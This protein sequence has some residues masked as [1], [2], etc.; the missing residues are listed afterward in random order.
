ML[1]LLFQ[2]G[3]DRYAL[4][5]GA[6]AEVL[7]LVAITAIPQAPAG[8]AGLFNYRGAPVPAIDLS[9]LT[10]GR[11]ARRRLNTRIIMVHY[12]DARGDTASAGSHRREGHR[13]RAARSRGL[14][15]IRCHRRPRPVPGIGGH[16]RA[17]AAADGVDV[18]RL[19][20]LSV[21]M[22]C[23]P[24]RREPLMALTDFEDLLKA[25]IGLDVELDRRLLLLSAPCRSGSRHAACRTGRS[26]GS[27]CAQAPPSCR[28]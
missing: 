3:Q 11:P 1:F 2:L 26:T 10:M 25:S 6:I 18:E 16:R 12:P 15:R 22:C 28:R 5:T 27:V 23:S 13:D 4:D 14:C 24:R 21:R 8:V 20:P 17:R 19:L 7:P 9:Q